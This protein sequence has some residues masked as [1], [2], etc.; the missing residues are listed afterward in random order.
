MY[1][2]LHIYIVSMMYTVYVY[3]YYH[4]CTDYIHTVYCTSRYGNKHATFR[5]PSTFGLFFNNNVK[6][7]LLFSIYVFHHKYIIQYVSGCQGSIDITVHAH[8]LLLFTQLHIT[9]NQRSGELMMNKD[10]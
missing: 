6:S 2:Q 4:I 10:N 9:Q 7:L 5:P 3:V 8:S 1:V